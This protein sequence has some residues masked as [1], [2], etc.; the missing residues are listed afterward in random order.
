MSGENQILLSYGGNAGGDPPVATCDVDIYYSCGPTGDPFWS[1]VLLLL[2]Q[3]GS[4]TTDSSSFAR[5]VVTTGTPTL[6]SGQTLFGQDTYKIDDGDGLRVNPDGFPATAFGSNEWCIEFWHYCTGTVGSGRIYGFGAG[7]TF[8]LFRSSTGVISGN[9][10]NISGGSYSF[11]SAAG[12]APLN[13]W[14]HIAVV[15]DNYNNDAFG[16]IRVYVNGTLVASSASFSRTG[17]VSYSDGPGLRVFLGTN[18]AG[19]TSVGYYAQ[20]R[21]TSGTAR[22]YHNFTVPNGPFDTIADATFA[23]A[24]RTTLLL[25]AETAADSS[26]YEAKPVTLTGSASISAV[27]KRF[28]TSSFLVPSSASNSNGVQVAN[29]VDFDFGVND[30]TIECW[31]RRTSNTYTGPIFYFTPTS[32]ATV[33][34]PEINTLGVLILNYGSSGGAQNNIS[35]GQTIALNTWYNV[36]I[37]RRSNNFECYLNGILVNTTAVT[38]GG[39]S[40]ISM[41]TDLFIGRTSVTGNGFGGYID[42]FRITKGVARYTGNFTPS[43]LGFCDGIPGFIRPTNGREFPRGQQLT[44]ATGTL[45]LLNRWMQLL[46]NQLT[47]S[48]GSVL[49]K[50]NNVTIRLE[51]EPLFIN[52]GIVGINVP[53]ELPTSTGSFTFYNVGTNGIKITFELDGTISVVVDS[54]DPDYANFSRQWA[55]YS[56]SDALPYLN[57][58][59]FTTRYYSAYTNNPNITSNMGTINSS[60]S[61]RFVQIASRPN[62][63]TGGNFEV[64]ILP[65]KKNNRYN[66]KTY[67]GSHKFNYQINNINVSR[68]YPDLYNVNFA[69]SAIYD[70]FDPSV[71]YALFIKFDSDGYIKFSNDNAFYSTYGLWVDISDPNYPP[72][73]IFSNF[74]FT[75]NRLLVPQEAISINNNLVTILGGYNTVFYF[76]INVLPTPT[77]PRFGEASYKGI[78]NCVI[79]SRTINEF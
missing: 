42:E 58:G 35:T 78:I 26:C 72:Q 11:S 9:V 44:T 19:D 14:N 52:S 45:G 48:Q 8:N 7:T 40:T 50:N 60:T 61:S 46:G 70:N 21:M 4:V 6:D 66:D 1:G 3:T 53:I 31:I 64:Y 65:T 39:T 67:S 12:A 73:S 38:G 22:Y 16:Y 27:E 76:T 10:T 49:G 56:T 24:P 47:S 68:G 55:T 43:T 2:N 17:T 13:Q 74:Q 33:F 34:R 37:Q 32:G 36:T 63:I 18:G 54:T 51:G 71:F 79:D 20:Y 29:T 77:N 15:R 28:G 62:E 30:F 59:Y 25:H 57:S 5:T 41:F 69:N 75:V 23:T